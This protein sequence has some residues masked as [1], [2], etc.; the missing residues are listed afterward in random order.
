MTPTLTPMT[1]DTAL[2]A[3]PMV[4]DF[5]HVLTVVDILRDVDIAEVG[6]SS[7][8]EPT[9]SSQLGVDVRAS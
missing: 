3:W 2:L 4:D 9:G 7:R 5:T 8:P 1:V 6:R